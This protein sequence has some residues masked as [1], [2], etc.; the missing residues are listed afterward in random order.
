MAEAGFE[1]PLWSAEKL[2]NL[3]TNREH[4]DRQTENISKT[5]ATLLLCG[6]SGERANNITF[7][8][9]DGH[10]LIRAQFNYLIR[11]QIN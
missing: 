4:T 3:L 11:A 5:E 7:I 2:E 6:S 10:Y 9:K 1:G 8:E